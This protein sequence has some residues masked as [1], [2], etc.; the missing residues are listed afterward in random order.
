MMIL[1]GY[2]CHRE[3]NGYTKKTE[4]CATKKFG[5]MLRGCL[6]GKIFGET[7]L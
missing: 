3:M 4:C 6:V 2:L 5:R 7:L 1:H